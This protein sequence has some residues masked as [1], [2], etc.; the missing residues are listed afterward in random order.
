MPEDR[1]AAIIYP[2]GKRSNTAIDEIRRA[3][4]ARATTLCDADTVSVAVN[5]ATGRRA[6][7]RAEFATPLARAR[8]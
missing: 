5:A 2:N 6:N 7:A 3:S 1:R 8:L 4:V